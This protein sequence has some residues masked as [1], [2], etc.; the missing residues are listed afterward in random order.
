[1]KFW[2]LILSSNLKK[3]G[4][5][6][7][8][9]L[10]HSDPRI[11]FLESCSYSLIHS[12]FFMKDIR[13]LLLNNF[14]NFLLLVE[15]WMSFSLDSFCPFQPNWQYFCILDLP[16]ILLA[17]IQLDESHFHLLFQYNPLFTLSFYWDKSVIV[18]SRLL[19][20][21]GLIN[22]FKEVYS[23]YLIKNPVC[24]SIFWL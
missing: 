1:M 12:F 7:I 15:F 10:F 23:F 18:L 4:F 5:F 6:L 21:H 24:D 14:T 22:R 13:V 2:T 11:Q 8:N 3:V 9:F 19:E 16:W 20:S 17:F